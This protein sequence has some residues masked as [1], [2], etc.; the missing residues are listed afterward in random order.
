MRRLG[1]SLSVS[2]CFSAHLYR[3]ANAVGRK[4]CRG[5]FKPSL[6]GSCS[7]PKCE[8]LWYHLAE[9]HAWPSPIVFK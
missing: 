5:V 4:S 7:P 9:R 3:K 8:I 6:S 1:R 2:M